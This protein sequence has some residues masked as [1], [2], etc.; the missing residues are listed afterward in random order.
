MM[1]RVVFETAI[2]YSLK[3]SM[4]MRTRVGPVSQILI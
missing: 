3:A 1:S 4:A 2:W